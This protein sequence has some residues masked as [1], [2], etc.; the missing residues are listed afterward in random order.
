MHMLII[1]VHALGKK[2]KH[3]AKCLNPSG[4][5]GASQRKTKMKVFVC[6]V[7][8]RLFCEILDYYVFGHKRYP[9]LCPD[10]VVLMYTVQ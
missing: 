8:K 10:F 6:I 2:T 4:C 7:S 9:L 5:C 3:Y 1:T